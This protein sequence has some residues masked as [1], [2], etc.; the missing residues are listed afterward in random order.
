[1]YFHQLPLWVIVANVPA[2]AYSFLL[3]TVTLLLFLADLFGL[4]ADMIG[5]ALTALTQVFH[6]AVFFFA[7]HTPSPLRQV[8]LNFGQC[9]VVYAALISCCLAVMRRRWLF[10]NIG[11]SLLCLFVGTL[12]FQDFRAMR[13]ERLIVYSS[14]RQALAD[15]IFGRRHAAVKSSDSA[16]G[17]KNCRYICYPARLGYRARTAM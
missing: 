6:K 7:E 16:A 13:Q 3:M 2:A 1:Y 11:L 5:A 10:F 8:Y 15:Y 17:D 4:P 12:A 14:S 9:L